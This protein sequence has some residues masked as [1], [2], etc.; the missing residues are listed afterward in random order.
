MGKIRKGERRGMDSQGVQGRFGGQKIC[1]LPW[2]WWCFHGYKHKS[3]L[4]KLYT[5]YIQFTICQLY[6][7]KLLLIFSN[8]IKRK[9]ITLE[10]RRLTNTT[11][12]KWPELLSPVMGQ[13]E[14]VCHQIECN[15]NNTARLLW[16]FQIERNQRAMTLN[17]KPDIR[18]DHFGR[19][20][21][22]WQILNGSN[23]MVVV[24]QC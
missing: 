9:L 11:S 16:C 12:I 22:N 18:L 6:L 7:K 4:C 21:D 19:L 1:S 10:W 17:V 5:K 3:K 20:W 24:Y 2:L 23:E 13:I 15:G 8:F 14:I